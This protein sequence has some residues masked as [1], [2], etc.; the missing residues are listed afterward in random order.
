MNGFIITNQDFING[1]YKYDNG[2]NFLNTTNK[3]LRLK[4]V[5]FNKSYFNNNPII[6]E[7]VCCRTDV[8]TL[9]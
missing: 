6:L 3:L 5:T 2:N 7:F 4:K 1:T 9:I 8:S